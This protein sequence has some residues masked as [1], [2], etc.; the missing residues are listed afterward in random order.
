MKTGE[1][2][3]VTVPGGS[4]VVCMLLPSGSYLT[5]C[6]E[7]I[8][9]PSKGTSE[10]SVR[11]TKEQRETFKLFLDAAKSYGKQKGYRLWKRYPFNN[12]SSHNYF[13]RLFSHIISD[14]P[15]C[16][17]GNLFDTELQKIFS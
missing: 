6:G 12:F 14:R 5:D 16:Q 11:L 9:L 13:A 17:D 2:K 4:E 10:K 8:N 3:R 15:S 1:I 7:L